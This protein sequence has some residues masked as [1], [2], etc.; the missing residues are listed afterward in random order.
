[1][2]VKDN[3]CYYIFRSMYGW[4]L[5]VTQCSK[6][7]YVIV[8]QAGVLN[9]PAFICKTM[10]LSS[11]GLS[12]N[13]AISPIRHTHV[14]HQFSIGAKRAGFLMTINILILCFGL[15]CTCHIFSLDN[16]VTALIWHLLGTH[17]LGGCSDIS[18]FTAKCLNGYALGVTGTMSDID[19]VQCVTD[20]FI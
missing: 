6:Y 13:F 19:S 3:L 14:L 7:V 11:A 5:A 15:Y 20:C 12:T 18:F 1:M 4:N 9:A 8:G 10:P 16:Q 17:A 2:W